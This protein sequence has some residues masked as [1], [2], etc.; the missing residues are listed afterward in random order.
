MKFFFSSFAFFLVLSKTRS[1]T[2][3]LGV[4]YKPQLT[5][6]HCRALCPSSLMGH[7]ILWPC[8]FFTSLL[9]PLPLLL[10]NRI[11]GCRWIHLCWN[12]SSPLYFTS[13]PQGF[14]F[15]RELPETSSFNLGKPISNVWDLR[16]CGKGGENWEQGHFNGFSQ[17]PVKTPC[18]LTWRTGLAGG[19]LRKFLLWDTHSLLVTW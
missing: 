16:L 5:P 2:S 3:P 14:N 18:L 10:Q 8:S 17:I 4:Q 9:P 11:A 15:Q 7:H 1:G 13:H 6:S 12:T 19:S